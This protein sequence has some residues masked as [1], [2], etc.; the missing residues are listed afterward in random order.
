[1][2]RRLV[3]AAVF[4]L[5]AG[6][7]GERLCPAG[8][9]MQDGACRIATPVGDLD[10]VL[11]SPADVKTDVGTDTQ[12]ALLTDS[13]D[14]APGDVLDIGTTDAQDTVPGDAQDVGATDAQDIQQAD[15]PS[16]ADTTTDIAAD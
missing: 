7:S 2:V 10:L 8:S 15:E 4:V 5:G 13:Q 6:C 11:P 14:T 3:V 1:M 16:A 9:V 12:D